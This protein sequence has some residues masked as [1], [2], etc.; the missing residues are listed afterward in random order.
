MSR[1]GNRRAGDAAGCS[2]GKSSSSKNL[3]LT[4]RA[5][6]RQAIPEA[7]GHFLPGDGGVVRWLRGVAADVQINILHRFALIGIGL[8]HR[9]NEPDAVASAIGLDRA[10]VLRA[11]DIGVRRGWLLADFPKHSDRNGGTQRV[12]ERVITR[13]A[14][15]P[16]SDDDRDMEH[17]WRCVPVPPT[18]DPAWFVVDSSRDYKTVW[19]RW[20][21]SGDR[22]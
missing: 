3:E 16:L 18:G 17:S 21:E 15:V 1:N 22:Q 19:G 20:H 2:V 5:D 9:R 4:H 10:C 7:Y 8:H 13:D 6:L 12:L 11:I 14:Q